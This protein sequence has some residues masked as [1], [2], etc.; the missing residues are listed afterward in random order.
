ML[1]RHRNHIINVNNERW[2]KLIQ[3]ASEYGYINLKR[4]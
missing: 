4:L 2:K 1:T 3:A